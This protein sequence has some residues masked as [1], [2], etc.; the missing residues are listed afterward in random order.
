MKSFTP[1][2]VSDFIPE[3]S[4]RFQKHLQSINQVFEQQS[5]HQVKTPTLEYYDTLSNAMGD[6]LKEQAIKFVDRSGHLLILRPDHTTPI[7]RLAATRM[8]QHERPL[9]L[10]YNDAVFRLKSGNFCDAIERF[11]VG[12]ELI[13]AQGI[14]AEIEIIMLCMRALQAMGLKDLCLN[15]G[16]MSFS[17]KA[18]ETEKVALKS[19][20]YVDLRT[21][22]EQGG[23]EIFEDFPELQELYRSCESQL[24]DCKVVANKGLVQGLYYYSGLIFEVY[25]KQAADPIATGGRYDHLIEKFGQ[26]EPAVGFGIDLTLIEEMGVQA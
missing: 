17:Q 21:L 20:N 14:Q 22:P 10:S 5:Y 2:G 15:L 24:S 4:A 1:Y 16:H 6:Y 26:A 13:G 12:A 9:K 7:A 3:E 23:A 8:S 19:K 25:A 18:S 11:Q